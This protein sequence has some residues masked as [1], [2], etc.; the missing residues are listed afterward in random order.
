MMHSVIV[1]KGVVKDKHSN[2]QIQTLHYLQICIVLV[3][4]LANLAHYLHYHIGM[5]HHPEFCWHLHQPES[6]QLSLNNVSQ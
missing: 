6:H 4:N 1:Y 3:Q 2:V 5:Y